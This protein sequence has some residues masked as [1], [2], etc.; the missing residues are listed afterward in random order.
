MKTERYGIAVTVLML[1][2]EIGAFGADAGKKSMPIMTSEMRQKMADNHQKMAD[3]LRSEKPM[4][5]CKQEM[6]KSCHETMGKDGCPMMGDMSGHMKGMMGKGMSGDDAAQG[7]TDEHTK[8]H[9]EG[10]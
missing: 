8:H 3:C 10:Q 1:L 4:S 2:F 7:A 9:P 5:E 6:M